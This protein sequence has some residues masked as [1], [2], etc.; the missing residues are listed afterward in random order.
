[1]RVRKAAGRGAS[2]F[3]LEKVVIGGMNTFF[4]ITKLVP[5]VVD[6]MLATELIEYRRGSSMKG[7]TVPMAK[8]DVMANARPMYLW[9]NDQ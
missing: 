6:R 4:V 5:G 8:L 9:A 7:R 3:E 2:R 1:M